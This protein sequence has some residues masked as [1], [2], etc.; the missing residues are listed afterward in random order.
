MTA[1]AHVPPTNRPVIVDAVR[2][3]F[4]HSGGVFARYRHHELAALPLRAL[5]QRYPGLDQ[6]VELLTVGAVVQELET[7]NIAREAGLNAGLAARIP[8]YS[9]SMAGV[10]PA[11]GFAHICDMIA[12]GRIQVGLAGGSENFSDLPIRLKRKVRQ[13]AVKLAFARNGKDKLRAVAG[14]WPWDLL[15]EV[16][17]S[18]DLSTGLTMGAACEAMV[19]RFGVSREAA[20]AFALR[21]HLNACAAWDAGHYTDEVIAVDDRAGAAVGCDDGMRRD[22]SAQKLAQLKPA[23]SSDGVVTAGNASGITD[24]AGAQLLMSRQRAQELGTQ[25]LAEVVDYQ[26]VGVNDLHTEMLLGPAMAIPRLLARHQL[27]MNDIHVFELHEAFAAQVL[28]NQKALADTSFA[29]EELG[30]SQA[31]GAIP[32]D[33]LNCWGGSVA[34]GNPFAGTGTRLLSTAARRLRASGGRYALTATCAGG[35]LGAA[36]LLANPDHS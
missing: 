23:F 4:L 33:R 7:T 17:S 25:P 34:L 3:P 8:A 30:L 20:D 21:S 26:L 28:C 36:I 22:T 5:L 29:Q 12:L 15:P 16:P 9:V 35:G 19:K 13:R 27:Q 6:Q 2:T 32:E 24:G 14:L 18:K 10:S 1:Y 31:T 11:V